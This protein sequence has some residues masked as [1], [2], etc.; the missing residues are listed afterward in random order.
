MP[1]LERP[2]LRAG[3]EEKKPETLQAYLMLGNQEG[4]FSES[5]KG[6]AQP[7][8][9]SPDVERGTFLGTSGRQQKAKGRFDA[10]LPERA[11]LLQRADH[12]RFG[13]L[14]QKPPPVVQELPGQVVNFRVVP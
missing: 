8:L 3:S 5:G 12:R 14:G 11:P 6:L 9:L 2:P 1:D 10:E 13:G 4:I 7:P